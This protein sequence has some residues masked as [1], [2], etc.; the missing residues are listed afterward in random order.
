MDSPSARHDLGSGL[1]LVYKFLLTVAAGSLIAGLA[2]AGLHAAAVRSGLARAERSF[3]Q[4]RLAETALFLEAL[5]PWARC[6]PGRYRENAALQVRCL[7]RLGRL[8]QAGAIAES[9]RGEC[10]SPVPPPEWA[11]LPVDPLG[12]LHQ[13]TLSLVSRVMGGLFPPTLNNPWAGYEA[14]IEELDAV[15]NA[16]ALNRLADDL[17]ARFPQS[18]IALKAARAR[19]PPPTPSRTAEPVRPDAPPNRAATAPAPIHPPTAVPDAGEPPPPS[20]SWGIV[21]N[22]GAV[23]FHPQTGQPIRELKPGD[24]LAIEGA[25]LLRNE[26]VLTGVL[27]LNNRTIPEIA[28]RAE[29]LEIRPGSFN[30]VPP[31]EVALRSRLA[32]I[33]VEES[34]LSLRLNREKTPATPEETAYREA[35][36]RFDSF[37]AEVASLT[38]Q[39]DKKTGAER[40]RILDRLR[41]M[42]YQEQTLLRTLSERKQAFERIGG[43]AGPNPLARELDALR[44]E[45]QAILKRLTEPLS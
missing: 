27:I 39:M 41:T 25:V 7:A 5:S 20:A 6:F 23:A 15:E 11:R 28:F 2:S 30:T 21:T 17:R 43:Q 35:Q 1:E 31:Q 13:A 4:G 45:K 37:Q 10:D 8:E 14:I 33:A 26:P 16:D 18:L 12:W 24:V 44:R 32:E 29:D 34:R 9:M 38:G 42:K 36:A 3:S 22:T 40:M 19:R